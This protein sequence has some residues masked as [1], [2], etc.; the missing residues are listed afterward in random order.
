MNNIKLITAFFLLM[1]SCKSKVVYDVNE[2]Q[3]K[4]VFINLN[5]EEEINDTTFVNLKNYS[6]DFVYDLKYATTDNFL[7]AKVYDCAECYL[8]LKTVKA[9][10]K[11]NEKA[12]KLGYRIK[13][14]D[15]YR[16][17][18][19]QKKMWEIISDPNYVANPANG[20]IHNKGAAVDITLVDLFEN[21]LDMG[22]EFDFFGEKASHDYLLLSDSI[23]ENR[24]ELKKVMKKSGFRSFNS[25]W[26][27][28][29]LSKGYKYKI[30]NFKWNCD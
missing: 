4:K 1:I 2:N 25:E 30:S 27:H 19:V 18:D 9:L 28:Y 15:C 22:T 11:A 29:N 10:L 13:L 6:S 20:S 21:E 5:Q 12:M 8:R 17:I 7:K 14:F 26:W 24:K 3:N 16:P 23:I